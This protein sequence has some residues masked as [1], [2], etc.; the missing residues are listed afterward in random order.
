MG[1]G[2][3]YGTDAYGNPTFGNP[4][5][6]ETSQGYAL[7]APTTFAPGGG[8]AKW[9]AGGAAVAGGA[10]AAYNGFSHGGGQGAME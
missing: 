1:N 10:F 6:Q 7:G 3:T 5:Y 2:S 4:T 9:V 8:A